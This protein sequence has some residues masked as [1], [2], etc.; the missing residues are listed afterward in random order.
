MCG[1]PFVKIHHIDGDR[2][3]NDPDNLIPLCGNHHTIVH[4][5][6]PPDAGV[7]SITPSQLRL[8]RE[9]WI[10]RCSSILPSIFS[11]VE[12]LKVKYVNLE[13]EVRK[14]TQNEG[15]S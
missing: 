13:G 6:P 8:Y 10:A 4:L 12:E 1:Q 3:N 5:E 9:D 2:T 14:L 11:D 15:G 7:Q